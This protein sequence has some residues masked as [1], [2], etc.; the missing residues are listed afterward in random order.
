MVLRITA[1]LMASASAASV[2]TALDER[3]DV[4]W[5]NEAHI[6]AEVR[7]LA[8]PIV[9]ATACLHANQTLRKFFEEA[10][11]YDATQIPI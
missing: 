1:S 6:M 4:G 2:F 9:S 3:F 7:D 11:H 8:R 5:W 10:Q